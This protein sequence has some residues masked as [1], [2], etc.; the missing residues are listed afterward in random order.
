[1]TGPKYNIFGNDDWG[2]V[3]PELISDING[4]FM[5]GPGINQK[6]LLNSMKLNSAMT[7]NFPGN[8]RYRLSIPIRFDNDEVWE[9]F[10]DSNAGVWDWRQL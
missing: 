7:I 4:N 8:N 2:D 10:L 3:A 1:V 9:Y 5:W 6:P